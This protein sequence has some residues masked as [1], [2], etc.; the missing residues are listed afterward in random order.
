MMAS[1]MKAPALTSMRMLLAA[2]LVGA[3]PAMA[4]DLPTL[5][6]LAADPQTQAPNWK[7]FYVGTGVIGAFAKGSKSAFGGEVF[8]GYDHRFDDNVVLGV[9]FSTGYS[10]WLFPGAPMQGFDFA[11]SEVKVGYEMGALT[12]Y[13]V[14][15][16]ALARPT[17]YAGGFANMSDSVNGLFSGPGALQAAGVAGVG[18]DY[19]V[20]NNLHVGLEATVVNGAAGFAH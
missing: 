1:T 8:A 11:A 12:P 9:R 14:G 20:T 13:L 17:N 16:V 3:T 18:F 4:A 15:G 19:A 7:G 10:P 2:A 5:P 6:S